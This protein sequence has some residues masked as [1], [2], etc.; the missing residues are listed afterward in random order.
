MSN[1]DFQMKADQRVNM[2]FNMYTS[3]ILC[4][5]NYFN[6]V[7]I[8]DYKLQIILRDTKESCSCSP[9]VFAVLFAARPCCVSK[10]SHAHVLP[11]V[12]EE[13]R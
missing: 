12:K 2:F 4:F 13:V 6:L 5:E 8:E 7:Y 11:A 9:G 3:S 10:K 1:F